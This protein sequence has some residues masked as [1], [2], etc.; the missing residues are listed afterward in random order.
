MTTL[1]TEKLAGH[2]SMQQ[3]TI[4]PTGTWLPWGS[5][6]AGTVYCISREGR[7]AWPLFGPASA[8]GPYDADVSR[9]NGTEVDRTIPDSDYRVQNAGPEW[10]KVYD[11]LSSEREWT[12]TSLD[13]E[14]AFIQLHDE[15]PSLISWDMLEKIA[16]CPPGW[17][18]RRHANILGQCVA[19]GYTPRPGQEPR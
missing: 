15:P 16:A 17:I 1:T 9:A 11:L 18:Q 12:V 8:Y 2:E 7:F 10:R 19:L 3:I 5:T 13:T 6:E 14:G 4:S